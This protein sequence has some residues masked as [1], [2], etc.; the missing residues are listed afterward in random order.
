LRDGALR[1]CRILIP[2]CGSGHD[3]A[4]LAG[5]GFDVTALDYA[6]EA[7]QLR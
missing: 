7:V 3:A 5:V 4:T 1:P 6:P 2:G